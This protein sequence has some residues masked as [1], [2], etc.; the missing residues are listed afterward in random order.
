MSCALLIAL[1]AAS[2]A[3]ADTLSNAG[4]G[5]TYT[6]TSD[7][8][9]YLLVGTDNGYV[10]FSDGADGSTFL[11]RYCGPPSGECPLSGPPSQVTIT[12]GNGDHVINPYD[13]DLAAAVHVTSG[14]GKDIVT[15]PHSGSPSTASTGGGDDV[16]SAQ[17]GTADTIDCGDG[18]DTVLID[19]PQEAVDATTGCEQVVTAASDIRGPSST[20]WPA[21]HT[22]TAPALVRFSF[23]QGPDV[24]DLLCWV[25]HI[26]FRGCMSPY[27]PDFHDGYNILAVAA[28]LDVGGQRIETLA[29]RF[30]VWVYPGPDAPAPVVPAPPS[31][32]AIS[33]PAAQP[34]VMPATLALTVARKAQHGQ[35]VIGCG[36][37]GARL[38]TCD[39]RLRADGR[40]VAEGF[41]D[42]G[43]ARLVLS[44]RAVRQ[45]ARRGSMAARVI[46]RA[47][48]TD[49]RRLSLTRTIT[50][51][52]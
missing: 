44:S 43:S 36:A 10:I 18:Y 13:Y 25:L 41:A 4:G 38:K 40:T 27:L 28:R 8:P 52:R 45:L 9:L 49:G 48:T 14:G 42:G 51:R 16:I 24:T 46:L 11:T 37:T 3:G 19:S 47:T 22:A 6:Q 39:V 21:D 29:S 31:Q 20:D 15:L 1:V 32:V 35:L 12:L 33:P 34:A 23:V 50:I 30:T 5:A 7:D 2:P 17:N 26:G